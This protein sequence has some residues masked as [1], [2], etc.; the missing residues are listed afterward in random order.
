[1]EL[2]LWLKQTSLKT[3]AEISFAMPQT[4]TIATFRL[5]EPVTWWPTGYR[6]WCPGPLL[7]ELKWG[8]WQGS[9]QSC[10]LLYSTLP[11]PIAVTRDAQNSRELADQLNPEKHQNVHVMYHQHL[12]T[13]SKKSLHKS[14]LIE[15]VLSRHNQNLSY[16]FKLSYFWGEREKRN[17]YS[18][19][20]WNAFRRM[21]KNF[22]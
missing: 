19:W 14:L 7:T 8:L 17:K 9:W 1:M 5:T 22:K 12:K 6:D 11:N 20:N 16:Y 13:C 10:L 18:V 15:L 3:I 2:D 4:V 21:M